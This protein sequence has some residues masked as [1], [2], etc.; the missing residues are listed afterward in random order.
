M[1]GVVLVEVIVI[2]FLFCVLVFLHHLSLC[3]SVD[4]LCVDVSICVD[5][6]FSVDHVEDCDEFLCASACMDTCTVYTHVYIHT[7][8]TTT[9]ISFC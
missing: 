1:V 5:V 9:L 3:V 8:S 7:H 4:V 2:L 6:L